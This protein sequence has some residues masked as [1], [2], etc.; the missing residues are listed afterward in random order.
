RLGKLN[1]H[2]E[3]GL[4]AQ[5]GQQS[6]RTLFFY[7]FNDS[8]YGYRLDINNIG[9]GHIRHYRSGIAVYENN[10]IAFF[11]KGLACLCSRIIKLGGLSDDNG[12]AADYK[13]LFKVSSLW[14]Y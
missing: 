7:Y 14:H 6:V 9:G 4:T 3:S 5:S 11:L 1:G 8:F 2:I 12:P 13:N 10:I